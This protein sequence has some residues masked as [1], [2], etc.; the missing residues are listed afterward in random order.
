[1][2]SSWLILAGIVQVESA[3]HSFGHA[4]LQSPTFTK[5]A[6]LSN[7]SVNH[8]VLMVVL[9]SSNLRAW[10]ARQMSSA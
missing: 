3:R 2:F 1:M 10:W 7:V 9:R 8:L 4:R 6:D 5:F